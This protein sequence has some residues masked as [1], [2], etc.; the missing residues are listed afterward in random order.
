MLN[1]TLMSAWQNWFIV[2]LMIAIGLTGTHIFI[3][4]ID[5]EN[6]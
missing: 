1:F 5:P 2:F 6:A 4:Y 3:N